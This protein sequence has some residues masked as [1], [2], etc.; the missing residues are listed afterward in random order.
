MRLAPSVATKAW[1]TIPCSYDLLM[2]ARLYFTNALSARKSCVLLYALLRNSNCM[3]AC[4]EVFFDL[5]LPY[6]KMVFVKLLFVPVSK[7]QS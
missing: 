1:S 7:G 6:A 5:A 3:P 2:K 4:R